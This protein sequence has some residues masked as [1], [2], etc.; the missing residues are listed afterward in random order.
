MGILSSTQENR[1]KD[2]VVE[3][4]GEKIAK[5]DAWSDSGG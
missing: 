2:L 3:G 1:M 4:S 5:K